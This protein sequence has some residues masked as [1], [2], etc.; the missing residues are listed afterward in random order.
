MKRILKR[1]IAGCLCSVMLA[2][3]GAPALTAHAA[4]LGE[5]PGMAGDSIQQEAQRAIYDQVLSMTPEVDYKE[6][7]VLMDAKSEKDAER[8]AKLLDAEVGAYSHGKATLICGMTVAETM[9]SAMALEEK[10]PDLYPNRMYH[11]TETNYGESISANREHMADNRSFADGYTAPNDPKYSSQWHHAYIG[12]TSAWSKGV[13]GK[14]VTVAVLDTG[15]AA[16][17]PDLHV[18]KYIDSMRQW[19]SEGGNDAYD[20]NG[21]GTSVAGVIAAIAN[22][23]QGGTG[24]APDVTL[25]S[26]K[27]ANN[28]AIFYDDTIYFGVCDAVD[29]GADVISLSFQG[30]GEQYSYISAAVDYAVSHGCLIV[31]A[32]GN[33]NSGEARYPH[34]DKDVIGVGAI[35]KKGKRLSDCNYGPNVDM[36]AP[37]EDIYTTKLKGGYGTF[38]ATSSAAPVVAASAA[39]LISSVPEWRTIAEQDTGDA[40]FVH[41]VQNKIYAA[42]KKLGDSKYYGHGCVDVA[43]MMGQGGNTDVDQPDVVTDTIDISVSA[44]RYNTLQLTWESVAGAKTYEVYYAASQTEEFKRLKK[45]K[46]HSFKFSKAKCGQ[47]YYFKVIAY[48][49]SGK[50]LT[51]AASGQAFGKT[52]LAGEVDLSAKSTYNKVELKWKKVKGVK[53][54]VIRRLDGGVT[55]EVKSAKYT[56]K[57]VDAGKIYTYSVTAVSYGEEQKE[58]EVE[59]STYLS[60]APK[61]KIKASGS[62]SLRLS[63]SK[64]PGAV[65][66]DIYHV[67]M[68]TGERTLVDTV[69]ASQAVYL[70]TGLEPAT[71]YKYMVAARA[72]DSVKWS[73]EVVQRTKN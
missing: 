3:N 40:E 54:Y 57:N 2:G 68:M 56:D 4:A 55:A 7:V 64:V 33:R 52:Y 63:W 71:S 35:D 6:Y 37:G 36:M 66:Y 24:I 43:K 8:Y 20:H 30:F 26:C 58:E 1:S 9:E 70:L 38:G 31:S 47:T 41:A 12:S 65:F 11:L 25:I 39:L 29:A 10:L 62:D 42:A 19:S 69:P 5:N 14:G 49:K 23:N 34:A 21:H 45:T 46:N 17:H 50:T 61:L 22:N 44:P 48:Q 72:G 15:V 67:S 32:A 60:K 53:K 18:E 13:T 73:G 59:A 51:P 16:S 27:V 28:D